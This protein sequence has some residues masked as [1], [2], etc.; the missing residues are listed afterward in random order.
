MPHRLRKI[1]SRARHCCGVPSFPFPFLL[2]CLALPDVTF[3]SGKD[4]GMQEGVIQRG[5][6]IA[7]GGDDVP[8]HSNRCSLRRPSFFVFCKTKRKGEGGRGK[9]R[10]YKGADNIVLRGS[11]PNHIGAFQLKEAQTATFEES[12][13]SN[14]LVVHR[15]DIR[16]GLRR[17]PRTSCKRS[18]GDDG[19]EP[20][21]NYIESG[22]KISSWRRRRRSNF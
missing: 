5:A 16:R 18:R 3:P 11:A 2:P 15:L 22:H 7:L 6:A 13:A 1:R 14:N 20:T 21:N 8:I 17:R 10:L 12:A 9:G 19:F 4:G